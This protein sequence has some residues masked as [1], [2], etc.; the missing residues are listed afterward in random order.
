MRV[1]EWAVIRIKEYGVDYGHPVLAVRPLQWWS[2]DA[3]ER[4]AFG[5][6]T[7]IRCIARGVR[8]ITRQLLR[9]LTREG[10]VLWGIAATYAKNALPAMVLVFILRFA[11]ILV[12]RRWRFDIIGGRGSELWSV[13][14]HSVKDPRDER[15]GEWF[16]FSWDADGGEDHP[17]VDVLAIHPRLVRVSTRQAVLH[18]IRRDGPATATL[19]HRPGCEVNELPTKVT[20]LEGPLDDP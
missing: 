4:L 16:G 8:G 15:A 6:A 9:L 5:L 17:R 7:S 14:A 20:R 12:S 10:V 1:V 18:P 19:R 3:V 2:P 13:C 11:R